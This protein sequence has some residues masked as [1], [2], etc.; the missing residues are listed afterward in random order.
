[1][2]IREY[3]SKPLILRLKR[4]FRRKQGFIPLY[5]SSGCFAGKNKEM[6]M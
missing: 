3:G 1:M 4:L 2:E 6:A 5:I